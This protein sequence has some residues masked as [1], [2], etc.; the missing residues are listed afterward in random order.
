MRIN[1]RVIES[2]QRTIENSSAIHRWERI[3]NDK[4]KSAKR[5][6]ESLQI[7]PNFER[8]SPA[9]RAFDSFLVTA[10]ALKCWAITERPL[11]GLELV[12]S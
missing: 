5:T 11:R 2:A 9:S 12:A 8:R 4:P 6:A 10:P 7:I 1:H 3:I